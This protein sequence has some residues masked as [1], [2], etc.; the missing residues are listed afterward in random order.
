[1]KIPFKKITPSNN[2]KVGFDAQINDAKDGS[3]QSVAAWNDTTGNGYQDTSVYGVLT[4][5][6]KPGKPGDNG[7]GNTGGNSGGSGELAEV[8]RLNRNQ[9]N[10][11]A[12]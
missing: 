3:R 11:L 2:V 12:A 10:R 5:T 7:N 6:G 1:M 9:L 4:L 8:R